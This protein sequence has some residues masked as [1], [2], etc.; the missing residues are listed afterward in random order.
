MIER[1]SLPNRLRRNVQLRFFAF[2]YSST[3]CFITHQSCC[4]FFS[5]RLGKA[6]SSAGNRRSSARTALP[7]GSRIGRRSVFPN[8]AIPSVISAYRFYSYGS[9]YRC[10]RPPAVEVYLRIGS[11]ADRRRVNIGILPIAKSPPL[12]YNDKV[13]PR[14]T[15][16]EKRSA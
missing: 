9:T 3:R 2:P 16:R 6:S 11:A 10:G 8:H 15:A 12:R 7:E 1:S 14:G 5:N 4:S 13:S